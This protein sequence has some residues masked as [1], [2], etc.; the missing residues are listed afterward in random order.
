MPDTILEN[1]RNVTIHLNHNIGK[2]LKIRLFFANKWIMLSE[3]NFDSGKNY[4]LSI[5]L[6]NLK[7]F[8]GIKNTLH[9]FDELHSLRYNRL[10]LIYFRYDTCYILSNYLL[11]CYFYTSS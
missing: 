3:V 10:K 6:S 7:K 5:F 11:R 2:Y 1:A 8:N 4:N 9:N